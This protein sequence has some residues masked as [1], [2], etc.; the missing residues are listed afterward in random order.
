MEVS[1]KTDKNIKGL[2]IEKISDSCLHIAIDDSEKLVNIFGRNDE[3]LKLIENKIK[4]EIIPHGNKIQIKGTMGKINKTK[5]IIVD[6]LDR[7]EMGIDNNLDEAFITD[8]KVNSFY[9]INE[10]IG[11]KNLKDKI[12]VPLFEAFP[13]LERR[14]NIVVG[15]AFRDKVLVGSY[16]VLSGYFR[17]SWLGI[18]PNNKMINLRCCEIHELKENKIIESHILI[19]V[20]DFLRQCN[21]STINPSR[22]SEG[23]WLPPINT[24]GVN[25]FEKDIEVSNLNLKQALEMGRSLN[26]KPEKENLSNNELKE[27]LL[28][29]PQKEYWH[30]KMIWYGPCGIGT[31]RSLEGFIDMHQLPFR[32]SF[33]ERDYFKLGHYCEIGDGKFSLCAGWHSLEANYGSNDWLGFKANNQKLT[34]RVMDFYHHDE[35]KIRENWVPID[36][37]HILKQIGIDVLE[38]VKG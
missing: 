37:L 3:N 27:R 18:K 8:V 7:Y 33:T 22:G 23:A 16:S 25:F 6:M 38:K 36:I 12:W 29:H 17:N 34:M 2:T 31:S 1:L 10:F 32:R 26:I 24:D 14:E 30:N 19:D 4:V 15:G 11:V 20:M 21:I 5:D 28:N 13:D 9:P 35:G